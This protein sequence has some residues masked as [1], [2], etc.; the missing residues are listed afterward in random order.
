MF[1]C[2][3]YDMLTKPKERVGL[4]SMF[5]HQSFGVPEMEEDMLRNWHKN[6]NLKARFLFDYNRGLRKHPIRE[7]TYEGLNKI[8][9]ET[10][11]PENF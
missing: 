11:H 4:S 9:K 10:G 8:R 2:V 5:I 6:P 3:T 7:T 1:G